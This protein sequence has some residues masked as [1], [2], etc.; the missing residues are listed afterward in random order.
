MK[1]LSYTFFDF[2]GSVVVLKLVASVIVGCT[3]LL[4]MVC[5]T[6]LLTA[7]TTEPLVSELA[8]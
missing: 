3:L 6:T 2:S 4:G 8:D 5:C 1:R 7:T